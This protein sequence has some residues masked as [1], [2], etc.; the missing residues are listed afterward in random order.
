MISFHVII[1]NS[2]RKIKQT[3]YLQCSFGH[4]VI[5]DVYRHVVVLESREIFQVHKLL[6]FADFLMMNRTSNGSIV[7]YDLLD[8]LQGRRERE[9]EGGGNYLGPALPKGPRIFLIF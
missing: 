3:I 4:F 1:K 2:S 5:K 8:K 6:F 9:R 7:P